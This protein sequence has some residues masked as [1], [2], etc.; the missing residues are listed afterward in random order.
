MCS[1]SESLCCG[2]R[3]LSSIQESTS[4]PLEVP[5]QL[6]SSEDDQSFGPRPTTSALGHPLHTYGGWRSAQ[7]PNTQAEPGWEEETFGNLLV[8]ALKA[9]VDET[10]L[11]S[12]PRSRATQCILRRRDSFPPRMVYKGYQKAE[13][14]VG[15]RCLMSN[16]WLVRL[17]NIRL[18]LRIQPGSG[19]AGAGGQEK[20]ISI[21]TAKGLGARKNVQRPLTAS[22]E[23][24]ALR[25]RSRHSTQRRANVASQMRQRRGSPAGPQRWPRQERPFQQR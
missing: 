8:W 14:F 4:F 16:A 19:W 18:A 25:R 13:P 1:G 5:F 20:H 6:V 22:Q 9:G 10:W 23:L 2:V 3:N 21:R 15:K 7:S 17:L 11:E 12:R 24:T